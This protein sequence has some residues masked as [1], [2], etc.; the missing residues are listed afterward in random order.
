MFLFGSDQRHR[1]SLPLICDL[2]LSLS[3]LECKI[4]VVKLINDYVVCL[5]YVFG[6]LNL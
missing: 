5:L 6:F 1:G 2:C 3:H 4:C